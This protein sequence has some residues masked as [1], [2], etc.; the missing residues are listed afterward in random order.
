[1]MQFPIPFLLRFSWR[2]IGAENQFKNTFIQYQCFK[3]FIGQFISKQEE[4]FS[5]DTEELFALVTLA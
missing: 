4:N 1:M 2:N 5:D 3:S